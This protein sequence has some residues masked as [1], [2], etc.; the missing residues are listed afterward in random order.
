[1]CAD[2]R[3]KDYPSAKIEGA[4]HTEVAARNL[5]SNMF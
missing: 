4:D 1:M 5:K 2:K 3:H